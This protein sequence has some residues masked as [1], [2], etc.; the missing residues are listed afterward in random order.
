M[1]PSQEGGQLITE[2]LLAGDVVGVN[3]GSVWSAGT[4]TTGRGCSGEKGGRVVVCPG[5]V[6]VDGGHELFLG[7]RGGGH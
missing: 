5:P 1:S 4:D 2:L 7:G 3:R 6:K